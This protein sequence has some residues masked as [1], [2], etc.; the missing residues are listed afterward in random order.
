[1]IDRVYLVANDGSLT[2]PVTSPTP[3]G[4]SRDARLRRDQRPVSREQ[5]ASS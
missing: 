2:L 3:A 5:A 4:Q 1:M